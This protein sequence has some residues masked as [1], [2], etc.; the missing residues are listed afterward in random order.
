M[1]DFI[2]NPADERF[3]SENNDRMPAFAPH[4]DPKLNQLDDKSL[5]LVVDW[6]RGDWLRTEPVA[7][8]AEG[9]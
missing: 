5:G 4:D 1:I 2:R 8:N 7:Q 6:L 3:Y 9:K